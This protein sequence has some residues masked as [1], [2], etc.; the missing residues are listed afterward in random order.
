MDLFDNDEEK[1]VEL[2]RRIVHKMGFTSAFAVSGQTYSR[3]L[4]SRI[5]NVLSSIAQSASKFANDLRLTC[6]HARDRGAV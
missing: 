4:D 6:A 1:V 2:E 3:K 5:V